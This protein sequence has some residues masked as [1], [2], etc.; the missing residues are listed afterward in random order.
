MAAS[1]VCNS[2]V[3]L[4]ACTSWRP[5]SRNV[6][7]FPSDF[8]CVR[9]KALIVLSVVADDLANGVGHASSPCCCAG[10]TTRRWCC[11]GLRS[12]R[13]RSLRR[14]CWSAFGGWCGRRLWCWG[15]CGLRT[16]NAQANR[17]VY[18]E[19]ARSL[20]LLPVAR[21]CRGRVAGDVRRGWPEGGIVPSPAIGDEARCCLVGPHR[22][23]QSGVV[24]V[25][26]RSLP[27]ACAGA[28]VVEFANV[29]GHVP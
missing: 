10:R 26:D 8:R 24:V 3:V 29:T 20:P 25:V 5:Q 28:E 14:R 23:A 11:R 15:W 17:S 19:G 2:T 16:G 7:W 13:R 9:L 1:L 21:N 22:P 18:T 6:C 27:R 4:V 12:C